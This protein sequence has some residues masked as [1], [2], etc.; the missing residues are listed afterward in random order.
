MLSPRSCSRAE[1]ALVQTGC[2]VTQQDT[3]GSARGIVRLRPSAMAERRGGAGRPQACRSQRDARGGVERR[4]GR[5]GQRRSSRS[6]ARS[7][8]CLPRAISPKPSERPRAQRRTSQQ[9]RT[10]V[11]NLAA[12]WHHGSPSASHRSTAPAL[13]SRPL[14]SSLESRQ[15]QR[16]RD[17]GIRR[18]RLGHAR[19]QRK[20]Q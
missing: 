10:A 3:G 4:G 5:C 11:K 17:D 16:C 9:A 1:P 13:R 14:S 19:S 7:T 2:A 20:Q 6:A 12:W 18:S 8:E 15:S